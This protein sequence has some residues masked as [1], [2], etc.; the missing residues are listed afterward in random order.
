MN[1]VTQLINSY[2]GSE[3][4]IILLH[5]DDFEDKFKEVV[6][7]KNMYDLPIHDINHLELDKHTNLALLT[8]RHMLSNKGNRCVRI[9]HNMGGEDNMIRGIAVEINKFGIRLI[10]LN[11]EEV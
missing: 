1:S 4:T 11:K 7:S 8:F 3:D 10:N 6:Q 2:I 5:P 9:A